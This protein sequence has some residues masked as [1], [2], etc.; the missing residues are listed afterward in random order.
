M[1]A[2]YRSIP[3]SYSPRETDE[4]I[5]QFVPQQRIEIRLNQSEHLSNLIG[6]QRRVQ[7]GAQAAGKT[8]ARYAGPSLETRARTIR[9]EDLYTRHWLRRVSSP[10]L[11]TAG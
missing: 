4:V 6:T 7:F 3:S 1:V 8:L 11:F 2:R 9:V 5:A 10:C